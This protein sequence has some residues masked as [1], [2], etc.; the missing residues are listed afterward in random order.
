LVGYTLAAQFS[1]EMRGT[2]TNVGALWLDTTVTYQASAIGLFTGHVEGCGAGT[3]ALSIPL[4][5]GG[6]MPSQGAWR[7]CRAPERAR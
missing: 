6:S 1:G 4:V 7:S 2:L 5:A 3:M